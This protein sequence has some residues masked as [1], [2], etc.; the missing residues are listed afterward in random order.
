M[1][2]TDILTTTTT[3]MLPIEYNP[4]KFKLNDT[5]KAD[6]ELVQTIDGSENPVY[7]HV[8]APSNELGKMIIPKMATYYTDDTA[9]LKDTQDF[10]KHMVSKT[11][12]EP[13]LATYELNEMLN[14]WKDVKGETSF[15]EKYL[16]IEWEFAKFLNRNP[17]FLQ[18]MSVYNLLSPLV[19]LCIPIITLIIPFIII[20]M[21]NIPIS[22]NSYIDILKNLIANH[23][24]GKIFTQFHQVDA[25]QK[26]Y[27][28]VSAG[29]YIFSIYQ[30]ILVCLKLYS[31]MNKIQNYLNNIHKYL[32]YSISEMKYYA[33]I[34]QH[35]NSYSDFC[36]DLTKNIDL[37]VPYSN[38][39]A[40]VTE[41]GNISVYKILEFGD[42]LHIFYE[43]YDNVELT[44]SILYTFGFNGYINS[45]KGLANNIA[46]D[47]VNFCSF[48]KKD[49]TKIVTNFRRVYY[50]P[51]IGKSAVK[52]DIVTRPNMIITGPN[53][54]GKTTILKTNIINI[55]LSQQIGCG[56]YEGALIKPYQYIHCY[57][58]IPDTSGRDSL[59]QAEA[60]RCKEII[61]CI[62]INSDDNHFCIFDEL[63]S[64]TNPDEATTSAVAFMKYLSKR[65]NVSCMLTTHYLKVCKKLDKVGGIKNYSMKTLKLK[66][67]TNKYTYELQEGISSVKGGIKVLRDMNYP[68][69]ILDATNKNEFVEKGI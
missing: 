55:I 41:I 16:Y 39:L 36:K 24:I 30:N 28:V 69:E 48:G 11:S 2:N 23:A 37:L 33:E 13:T 1:S 14:I 7:E 5:I 29:F 53:A 38:R 65:K 52:N 15:H 62:D 61:D 49:D 32:V 17:K 68:K 12:G 40:K 8:F 56:T 57:L 26:L 6:L 67:G 42:I 22:V 25:G 18:I 31:N 51:L 44:N 21:Q 43:L 27:L 66:D 60:R 3:F 19:A 59:F 35:Y 47:A 9:Y 50:P 63:Y 46:N 10:I 20:K 34:L 54:S 64:G 58:N 4:R 45:L